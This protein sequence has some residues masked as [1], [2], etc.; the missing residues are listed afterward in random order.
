VLEAIEEISGDPWW[1]DRRVE[2]KNHDQTIEVEYI[3]P[4][5]EECQQQGVIRI[6]LASSD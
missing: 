4:T 2:K 1:R 3:C 5:T 6:N